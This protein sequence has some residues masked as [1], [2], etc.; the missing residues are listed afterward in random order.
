MVAIL[1]LVQGYIHYGYD[2]N[3]VIP[4]LA[5]LGFAAQRILPLIHHAY[6]SWSLVRGSSETI[7]ELQRRLEPTPLDKKFRK[8]ED[9]VVEPLEWQCISIL[10]INIDLGRV[11]LAGE[12]V[13]EK[14]RITLL[15][16]PSGTGKTTFL[17]LLVGLSCESSEFELS[18]DG[19]MRFRSVREFAK[20]S[21]VS[22]SSSLFGGTMKENL[23]L[24]TRYDLDLNEAAELLH[25]MELS[26]LVASLE[27]SS[28]V[29]GEHGHGL[30]AGQVQRV[31]LIQHLLAH[32][33]VLVLDEATNAID[34]ELEEVVMKRVK[35]RYPRMAILIVSHRSSSRNICNY[36]FRIH[37][38]V[39]ARV[40]GG[41]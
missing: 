4:W 6:S 3:R 9:F 36:A 11:T 25:D 33:D 19:D 13:L 21:Y 17:D 15:S 18:V 1:A 16:G 12:L 29:L 5:A 26:F 7:L 28:Y 35:A 2:V 34:E 38:G 40:D 32:P 24:L 10:N 37:D 20:I 41:A 23:S 14:G 27:S 39:L 31:I 22:Q 30:S 8:L